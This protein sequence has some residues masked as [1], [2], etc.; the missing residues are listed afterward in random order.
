M[1][2]KIVLDHEGQMYSGT[3]RNIS[4]TGALVEGLWN[5]PAGTTFKVRISNRH[6]VMATA[7]WCSQDRVGLEFADPLPRTARAAVEPPRGTE[8]PLNRRS[9]QKVG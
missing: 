1:L 5:V 7:R 3:V 2:R 9:I 6:A 4:A 8:R